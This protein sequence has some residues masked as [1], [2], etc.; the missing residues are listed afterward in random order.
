MFTQSATKHKIIAHAY[1]YIS[2][3]IAIMHINRHK[4][5]RSEFLITHVQLNYCLIYIY[6]YFFFD[7]RLIYLFIWC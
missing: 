3:F 5:S 2:L 4:D 7:K 1:T 6:I